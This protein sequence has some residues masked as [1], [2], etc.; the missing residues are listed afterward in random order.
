MN[1]KHGVPFE[2]KCSS[3]VAEALEKVRTLQQE[4]LPSATEAEKKEFWK[5][6]YNNQLPP[7][8]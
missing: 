2:I 4:P 6:A 3:C 1:C 7:R 5:N 8:K